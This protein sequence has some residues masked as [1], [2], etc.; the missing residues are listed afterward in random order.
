MSGF[1]FLYYQ[2]LCLSERGQLSFSLSGLVHQRISLLLVCLSRHKEK[3]FK[4][5]LPLFQLFTC[6]IE[7]QALSLHSL[8]KDTSFSSIASLSVS[9][10]ANWRAVQ[11]L[12]LRL[13]VISLQHC[14]SLLDLRQLRTKVSC[15]MVIAEVII[16]FDVLFGT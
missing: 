3:G 1:F 13:C 5:A 7:F 16:I 15:W 9:P 8:R 6:S 2:H 11:I 12:L 4:T 14:K 10:A